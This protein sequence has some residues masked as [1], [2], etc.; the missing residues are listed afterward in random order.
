M[1]VQEKFRCDFDY[2][3]LLD[4]FS[5]DP[6]LVF[7]DSSDPNS[8]SSIF[9]YIGFDPFLTLT[10]KRD[11]TLIHYRGGDT[12][13][14]KGNPLDIIQTYLS[15]YHDPTL[16]PFTAGAIGSF[17]YESARF[18]EDF[19]FI[20]PSLVE[21]EITLGFYD[22]VLVYHHP[23]QECNLYFTRFLDLNNQFS[24]HDFHNKVS[25]TVDQSEDYDIGDFSLDIALDDYSKKVD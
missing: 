23:S 25:M 10:V 21:H 8:S 22:K 19:K 11:V 2:I 14:L 5:N 15:K 24:F 3:A 20:R 16:L 9:S 18:L 7:L 4:S 12:F 13:S 17:S 1:A 6:Y